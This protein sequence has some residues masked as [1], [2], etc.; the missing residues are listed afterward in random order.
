MPQPTDT[1]YWDGFSF[2]NHIVEEYCNVNQDSCAYNTRSKRKNME[3]VTT[4][5]NQ[6]STSGTST[7]V[8]MVVQQHNAS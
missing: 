5:L 6:A 1:F 2:M 4:P 3:E 8:Q 7:H